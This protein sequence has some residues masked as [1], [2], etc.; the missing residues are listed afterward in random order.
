MTTKTMT[1]TC[2]GNHYDYILEDNITLAFKQ[3]TAAVFGKKKPQ[4]QLDVY[5]FYKIF[6]WHHN[7]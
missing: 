6:T 7:S 5:I 4:N 1:E 3:Q 2:G